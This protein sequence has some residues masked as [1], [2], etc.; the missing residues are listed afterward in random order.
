MKPS[1]KIR[2]EFRKKSDSELREIVDELE[3]KIPENRRGL[4]SFTVLDRCRRRAI[5]AS[6]L[7]DRESTG[8]KS[9]SGTDGQQS[10]GGF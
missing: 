9:E 2:E 8:S 5:A 6:L 10:L 4:L 7:D 3:E 1:E